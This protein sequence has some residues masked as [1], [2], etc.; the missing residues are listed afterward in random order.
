M[1]GKH[2]TGSK[3]VSP[4]TADAIHLSSQSVR[5][6]FGGSFP[7]G[8]RDST[9]AR[10]VW[11]CVGLFRWVDAN[12]E[13]R[14]SSQSKGALRLVLS[15]S[16]ALNADPSLVLTLVW[17]RTSQ[18]SRSPQTTTVLTGFCTSMPRLAIGRVEHQNIT[19]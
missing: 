15:P 9:S 4:A 19:P 11:A 17:S 18:C 14:R 2:A 8:C 16:G 6:R 1:A 5:L 13:S 10:T 7:Y 12:V 3:H